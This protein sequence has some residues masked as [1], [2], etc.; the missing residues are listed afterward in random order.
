MNI[1]E[2]HKVYK[3]TLKGECMKA[4]LA[5]KPWEKP[6]DKHLINRIQWG[7]QEV[8][9]LERVLNSDW[10]GYGEVNKE[11]ERA[12]VDSTGITYVHLTNSGSAAIETGLLALKADGRW[13]H[14]DKVI[15]PVTTFATSISSAINLG[16]QPI[17]IETKPGTYVADP[18]QV[19]AAVERFPEVRGMVLPHLLGNIPDMDKI[20]RALGPQRFLVED[21]CDTMGG[22]Y[23]GRK[24]GTFGDITAFSFYGSHHITA[25]GVGGAAATNDKRLQTLLRSLIFWGRDFRPGDEEFLKRYTYETLGTDSQMTGIQAAFGLAQIQKLPGYIDQRAQQFGEM[26]TLF[27]RTDFFDLPKVHP[28]AKPSWFSYPLTVKTSAPFDR[29][30]FAKY[31]TSKGVEVR[32]VMCGNITLQK[33]FSRVSWHSLNNGKFPIGDSVEE[34][35]LFVPC[36]GMLQDQKRDYYN[37]FEEF[38]KRY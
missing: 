14:G 4:R 27:S 31:L 2:K 19:I 37:I 17:F 25:G 5:W 32:P 33:P 3:R 1:S 16:M 13:Q 28:K 12:L 35:A 36:W 23:D 8:K 15:H 7:E 30:E 34:R 21:S 22:T 26:T 38:I 18:E 6:G 9:A 20:K 24:I 11:F 29:S 10:F